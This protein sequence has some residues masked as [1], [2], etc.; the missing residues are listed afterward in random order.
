MRKHIPSVVT[1]VLTSF[2]PHFRSYPTPL[3]LLSHM[4]AL[5]THL[6][7]NTFFALISTFDPHASSFFL[8]CYS[9][10]VPYSLLLFFH[11]SLLSFTLALSSLLYLL[12]IHTLALSFRILALLSFS[13]TIVLSTLLSTYVYKDQ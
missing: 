12:L 8:Y 5:M 7:Y 3:F 2:F 13:I 11:S 6:R 4:I 1:T 10:P 9:T